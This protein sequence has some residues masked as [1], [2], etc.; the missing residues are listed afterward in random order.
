MVGAGKVRL[1]AWP[2]VLL[3]LSAGQF[4]ILW[5]RV[6]NAA[7]FA[8]GGVVGAGAGRRH[9]QLGLVAAGARV[10]AAPVVVICGAGRH[11]EV[12]I[13]RSPVG[14]R[15]RETLSSNLSYTGEQTHSN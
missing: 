14:V 5:D 15:L 3:V 12:R 8:V 2:A 4:D 10:R 6:E 11:G 13:G 7:G 1:R 9:E